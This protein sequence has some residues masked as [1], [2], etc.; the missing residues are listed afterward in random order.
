[1]KPSLRV[2]LFVLWSAGA[3]LLVALLVHY[4]ADTIMR[5]VAATGWGLLVVT[6]FHLVPMALDTLA[7]A[8]LLPRD[9]TPRFARLLYLR[10]IGESVN[11]LLPAAQVGGDLVRARLVL[12][13]G[14]SKRAAA[15][16]VIV[17]LTLM[18]VS[19]FLFCLAGAL[20]LA[21][22]EQPGQ[23]THHGYRFLFAGVV[24][25]VL[26]SAALIML[27]RRGAFQGVLRLCALLVPTRDLSAALGG[28]GR[29]DQAIQD[30]YRRYRALAASTGWALLGWIAG[31]GEIW[32]ALYFLGHPIGLYEAFVLES[33]IQAVRNGAFFI[34]G[35]LGVQEGGLVLLGALFGLP[36]ETCLA[37]A[38]VKRVREVL[39]GVPGLLAWQLSSG[40]GLLRS[41]GA[42]AAPALPPGA[43]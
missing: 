34:P 14:V 7:W 22:H 11:G 33:L 41:R 2:M 3:L 35:A 39:L 6:L 8:A 12:H 31:T 17:N 16:S 19:L 27:Q 4:G 37:L 28:A 5:A 10:W 23:A 20:A 38:L 43:E 24:F 18:V 15:A 32:L 30:L 13:D 42:A 36:P 25:A 29:L 9:E 40:I 26:V 1:V 21:L